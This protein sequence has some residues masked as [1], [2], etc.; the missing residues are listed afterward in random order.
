M[1]DS[2]KVSYPPAGIEPARQYTC[3]DCG[4]IWN[5]VHPMSN[6]PR[7]EGTLLESRRALEQFANGATAGRE[8]AVRAILADRA[9]RNSL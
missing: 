1:T 4:R 2:L 7:C 9:P 3:K 5:T 8:R 6:C